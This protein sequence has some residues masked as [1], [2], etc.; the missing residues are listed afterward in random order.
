LSDL[1][2]PVGYSL[3]VWSS[4]G[5]IVSDYDSQGGIIGI[6]MIPM[7]SHDV[8]SRHISQELALN[9]LEKNT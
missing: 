1:D 4:R 3:V 5:E 7:L 6:G 9:N 2:S 8:L